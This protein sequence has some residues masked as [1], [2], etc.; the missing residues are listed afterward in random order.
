[1]LKTLRHADFCLVCRHL[2]F[3]SRQECSDWSVYAIGLRERTTVNNILNR[4]F[5][6]QNCLSHTNLQTSQFIHN[7]NPCKIF[8]YSINISN[9]QTLILDII[10]RRRRRGGRRSHPRTRS[11]TSSSTS[12]TVLFP[13]LQQRACS[14][15]GTLV[16]RFSVPE[17]GGQGV[18]LVVCGK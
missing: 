10:G 6:F 15:T 8:S 7:N 18:G 3:P 4:C 17:E 2:S 5:P 1:M 16:G 13:L 9:D 11:S 14:K 12:A